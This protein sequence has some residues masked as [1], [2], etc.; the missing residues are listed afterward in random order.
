[1]SDYMDLSSPHTVLNLS[2]VRATHDWEIE[3]LDSFINLLY[4]ANPFPGVM[5]S[6][7]WTPSSSHGLAVKCYYTMLQSCEHSSFSWK[8]GR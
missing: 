7:V 2:F 8:S 5:D 3:S 6:M 1:V 4:S